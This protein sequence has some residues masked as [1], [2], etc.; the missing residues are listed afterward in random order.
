MRSQRDRDGS[1]NEVHND[2]A[3]I[4]MRWSKS[5]AKAGEIRNLMFL[6]ER[7][8]ILCLFPTTKQFIYDLKETAWFDTKRILSDDNSGK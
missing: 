4:D 5:V 1:E 7:V 2:I 8:L 6:V 3:L